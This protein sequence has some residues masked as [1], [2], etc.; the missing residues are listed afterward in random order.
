MYV[1]HAFHAQGGLAYTRAGF[2]MQFEAEAHAVIN[3]QHGGGW[4][5]VRASRAQWA[6]WVGGDHSQP[7]NGVTVACGGAQGRAA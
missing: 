3:D 7:V 6:A 5:V 2:T 4:A 1:A